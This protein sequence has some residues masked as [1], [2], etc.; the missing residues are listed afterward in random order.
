M[1]ALDELGSPYSD[2]SLE[3]WARHGLG[4]EFLLTGR[5]AVQEEIAS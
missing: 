1:R 5:D 3:S 4:L 2:V